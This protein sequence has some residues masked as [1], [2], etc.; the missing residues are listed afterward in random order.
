MKFNLENQIDFLKLWCFSNGNQLNA[1]YSD[2]AQGISFNKRKTSFHIFSKYSMKI[3]SKRKNNK[4]IEV[5]T[6]EL[7]WNRTD[8]NRRH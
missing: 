3:Y 5:S 7:D 1:I 4:H 8:A 6:D 2:V